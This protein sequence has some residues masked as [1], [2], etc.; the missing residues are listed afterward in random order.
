NPRRLC[1]TLTPDIGF[2]ERNDRETSAA[3]SEM[4]FLLTPGERAEAEATARRLERMQS[5]GNSPKALLTLPRLARKDV[6][7]EPL[8]FEYS[9]ERIADRDFI[10]A[11]MYAGGIGYLSLNLWLEGLA[12]EDMDILPLFCE[13][14]GKTGAAGLD[15]AEMAEREAAATGALEFSAGLSY[16]VEGHSRARPKMGICLKALDSDWVKAL[17]ILSDRLFHAD[18]SDLERLRDIVLQSRVAW[19]NQI[20]PAG[21]AYASLYASRVLN[22]ALAAGER[23]SGC[24]QARF[25]DCLAASL[26]RQLK[27]LPDRFAALRDK[28][29]AGAAPALSLIGSDSTVA[30]SRRWLEENTGRFGGRS[31]TAALPLPAAESHAIRVGLAAPTE[32][33]FAALSL[34]AP[35]MTDADAPALVLLGVQLSYGYL[36]NEIRVKGGAYGARAGFDAGRGAFHFSS[37]RDPNILRTLNAFAGVE[38]FVTEE[39]DLSPTGIEQAIIGTVKTLDQPLRPPTAVIMALNRHLGGD[40]DAFRRSFRARLLGLNAEAVRGAAARVFAGL[41]EAPACVLASREKLTNENKLAGN[42]PFVIES[43]WEGGSGG[44]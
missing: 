38:G 24:T 4:L 35:A 37:F 15:Y 8:P 7:P 10:L 2:V 17:A 31:D 32:V 19:R 40:S 39:M 33:A 14:V 44:E 25:V 23:L 21:N 42:R 9:V 11:P 34:P 5:E 18:F 1:L 20:I 3:I 26:D 16:H 27:L 6:S 36:W 43:L 22:P 12:P 13:A 30:A 28:L 29:L 41:P